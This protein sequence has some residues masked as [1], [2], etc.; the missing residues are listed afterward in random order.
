MK[1]FFLIFVVAVFSFSLFVSADNNHGYVEHA[2]LSSKDLKA[3]QNAVKKLREL[4]PSW[5]NY[6]I[7][8]DETDATI[9]VTFWRP[10]DVGT[11]DFVQGEGVSKTTI[12]R[13][14]IYHNALVVELEKE[15]LKILRTSNIK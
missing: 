5:V 12:G 3:I 1:N 9:E 10:E 4:R 14:E 11:I 6:Q 15:S 2:T 7:A 13:Q 8:V